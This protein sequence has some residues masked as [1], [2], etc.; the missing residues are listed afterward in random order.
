M[1]LFFTYILTGVKTRDGKDV[2][3]SSNNQVTI[4]GKTLLP[5][6]FFQIISAQGTVS[7]HN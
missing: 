6:D 7:K 1:L 3:L 2:T 4:V 5:A